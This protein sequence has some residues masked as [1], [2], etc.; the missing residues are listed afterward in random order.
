MPCIVLQV[1]H[2]VVQGQINRKYCGAGI[3]AS[4]SSSFFCR[5]PTDIQSAVCNKDIKLANFLYNLFWNDGAWWV[6]SSFSVVLM[7]MARIAG[8]ST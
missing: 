2:F 5:L 8:S 7:Q 1:D 3:L 4:C 6:S